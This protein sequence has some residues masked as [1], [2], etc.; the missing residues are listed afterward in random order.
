MGLIREAK[1]HTK[2]VKVILQEGVSVLALVQSRHCV[3]E[4]LQPRAQV[5][6]AAP[7][8]GQV[9]PHHPAQ[10][11]VVPCICTLRETTETQTIITYII[12]VLSDHEDFL[13]HEA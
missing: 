1:G 12:W 8:T 6:L 9:G 3:L 5:L 2:G 4:L 7:P 10:R 11:E 13:Q